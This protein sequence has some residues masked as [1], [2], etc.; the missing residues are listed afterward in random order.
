V[1]SFYQGYRAAR[2]EL[3]RTRKRCGLGLWGSQSDA[4]Y[5]CG[6]SIRVLLKHVHIFVKPLLKPS[7]ELS[8]I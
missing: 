1:L 2:P 3:V 5:S 6:Q 4:R 8:Y 7:L